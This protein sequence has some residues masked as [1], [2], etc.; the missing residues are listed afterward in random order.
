M[1]K[2]E[3]AEMKITKLYVRDM[4]I[5]HF[6]ILLDCMNPVWKGS[7]VVK[8]ENDILFFHEK[9]GCAVSSI[10][11]AESNLTVRELHDDE[12]LKFTKD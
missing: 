12:I 8:T 11:S 5:G 1:L 2:I 6:Y 7:A 9:L 3:T 10:K 4:K